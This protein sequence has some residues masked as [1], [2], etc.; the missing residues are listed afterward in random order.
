MSDAHA[1][2][3]DAPVFTPQ[4][5]EQFHKDDRHAGGAVVLLMTLIFSIGICLYTVVAYYTSTS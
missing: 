5:I 2:H 1:T 4:Q 3:G